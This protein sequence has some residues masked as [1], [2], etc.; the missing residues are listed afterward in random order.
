MLDTEPA[1]DQGEEQRGK[2]GAPCRRVD[3]RESLDPSIDSAD[4]WGFRLQTSSSAG[5]TASSTI[6]P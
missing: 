4:D 1:E 2:R 6:T 3:V 5:A